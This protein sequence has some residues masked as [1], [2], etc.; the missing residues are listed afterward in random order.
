M[1][2][3][4]FPHNQLVYDKVMNMFNFTNKVA[5]VQATGTGKGFLAS[6]FINSKMFKGKN[7]LVLA[8]NSDILINYQKNFGVENSSNITLKLY[9]GLL[10]LYKG[11]VDKKNRSF[12][13]YCKNIDLVIIDEFHRVGAEQWGKAVKDLIDALVNR[14]KYV[15]GLS[16]TPTRYNDK[17][18]LNQ[19]HLSE[20]ERIKL[21]KARNMA[22]E[23]FGGNVVQGITL[24]EAVFSGVL[25]SFKYVL[26]SYGYESEIQTAIDRLE[27][28]TEN[29]QKSNKGLQKLKSEVEKLKKYG[30]EKENLRKIIKSEISSLSENQKWIVFCNDEE[31]LKNI[32]EDL[33]YWFEKEINNFSE[34]KK[35]DKTKINLYSV[36]SK[37]SEEYNK[38]NLNS[39]FENSGGLH[40]IKCINKLNEG[41]HVKD[42]TGVIMLRRT[43]SPI[44]YLQQIGRALSAGNTHN[45][46]IFDFIGNVETMRK[47]ANGLDDNLNSIVKSSEVLKQFNNGSQ[48]SEFLNA[49]GYSKKVKN[50]LEPCIRIIDKSFRIRELFDNIQDILSVSSSL[51]WKEV[52]LEILIKFYPL[53]G[54]Q[55]VHYQLQKFALSNRSIEAIERKAKSL[56]LKYIPFENKGNE[57]RWMPEEDDLVLRYFDAYKGKRPL[58]EIALTLHQT[59]LKNRDPEAIINH[60][61]KLIAGDR[62]SDY[63]TEDSGKRWEENDEIALEKSVKLNIP[64]EQICA[65]LGRSPSAVRS[66]IKRMGL[67]SRG[68]QKS[69]TP[70]EEL[71]LLKNYDKYSIKK[72]AEKFNIS[73]GA[74]RS[75]YTR[76][77][78]KELYSKRNSNYTE[79]TNKREWPTPLSAI[80][81]ANW[82]VD[83]DLLCT[84]LQPYKTPKQIKDKIL[85]D[86]KNYV[87]ENPYKNDIRFKGVK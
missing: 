8:P 12:E 65:E 59:M 85:L 35:I 57:L 82:G 29:W 58:K 5:V 34:T 4:L 78:E 9:Q 64:L 10:S 67:K 14:N 63:D 21:S 39:F 55:Q 11:E 51:D 28:A 60:Y 13:Y 71:W 32:D 77:K 62:N 27:D 43:L 75:K 66:K 3:K 54:A 49:C 6:A 73:E 44:I 86:C 68:S 61:H 24:E 26:G 81:D 1:K 87:V 16:A 56:G 83:W 25:P 72:L 23:V 80:L 17:T 42:V 33:S 19:V 47:V 46:I 74:I 18:V 37:F 38:N 7:I 45:P 50:N 20:E 79:P 40:I 2:E 36:F 15:L 22:D 48:G 53:G 31:Q 30:S 69:W 41:V 70:E 76:L 84:M 52:E